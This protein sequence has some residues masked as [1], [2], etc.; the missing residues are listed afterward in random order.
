MYKGAVWGYQAGLGIDLFKKLTIDARY[1][2]GF[3]NQFGKSINVGGQTMKLNNASPSVLLS[4][5]YMF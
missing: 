4:L 2:G 1:A 3:G 5:G